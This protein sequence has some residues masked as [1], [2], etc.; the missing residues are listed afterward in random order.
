MTSINSANDASLSPFQAITDPRNNDHPVPEV[1][2]YLASIGV[3][4]M[5]VNISTKKPRLDSWKALQTEA[6][7]PERVKDWYRQWPN[8]GLAV[9]TG[10][11][12]GICVLDLDV[13][14]GD[15][16]SGWESLQETDFV[17]PSSASPTP[18]VKTPS[19]GYHLYYPFSSDLP[20]GARIWELHHVDGRAEGGYV[21]APPST[22]YL[23]VPRFGAPGVDQE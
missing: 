7:S 4:V 1:A 16:P 10:E 19:G 13:G 6:A 2:R 23:W 11:L 12:N 22:G 21:I 15:E 3:S 18:I 9:V 17:L 8:A 5:P 14:D 20:Q